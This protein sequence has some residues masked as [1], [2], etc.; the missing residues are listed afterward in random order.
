MCSLEKEYEIHNWGKNTVLTIETLPGSISTFKAELLWHIIE[1]FKG[2]C[3][4]KIIIYV[5]PSVILYWV[6]TGVF[7]RAWKPASDFLF[8]FVPFN[9]SVIKSYPEPETST[10]EQQGD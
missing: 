3:F 5:S 10:F 7:G 2:L 9:A 4:L 8:D 1:L 6:Y